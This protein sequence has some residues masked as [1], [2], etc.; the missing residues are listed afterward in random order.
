MLSRIIIFIIIYFG[1]KH[2]LASEV[3]N[4][5]NQFCSQLIS[6]SKAKERRKPIAE[7]TTILKAA[8]LPNALIDINSD[9]SRTDVNINNTLKNERNNVL[10]STLGRDSFSKSEI[11]NIKNKFKILLKKRDKISKKGIVKKLL[12]SASIDSCYNLWDKEPKVQERY[13][14]YLLYLSKNREDLLLYS[15]VME[16]E[17]LN[18]EVRQ[19]ERKGWEVSNSLSYYDIHKLI[20]RSKNTNFVILAHASSDGTLFDAKGNPFPLGFFN[21]LDRGTKSILIFSCYG[22]F[23]VDRYKLREVNHTDFFTVSTKKNPL[24]KDGQTPVISLSKVHSFFKNKTISSGKPNYCNISFP[25]N[26]NSEIEVF[27]DKIFWGVYNTNILYTYD[28]KRLKSGNKVEL[29]ILDKKNQPEHSMEFKLVLS[30]KSPITFSNKF[31]F[32][33]GGFLVGYLEVV[34]LE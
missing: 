16:T 29:Y 21:S 25:S 20:S 33:T 7:M 8:F 11:R 5:K 9:F 6:A 17:A 24:L 15:K 28:C 32:L 12:R 4:L 26:I 18:R 10:L 3:S 30:N 22:N 27:V 14:E 1:S 13:E 19:L 2:A 34:N 23:V 31:S